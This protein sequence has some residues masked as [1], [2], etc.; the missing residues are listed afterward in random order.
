MLSKNQS[1]KKRTHW[2]RGREREKGEKK[3]Y[4]NDSKPK[5]YSNYS[6]WNEVA[7]EDIT[8]K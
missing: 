7:K 5:G 1:K 8:T 6:T 4:K 2:E 3:N